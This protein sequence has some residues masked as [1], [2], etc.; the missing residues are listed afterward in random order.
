MPKNVTVILYGSEARGDARP[1]SDIDIVV[2]VDQDH[3]TQQ[4]RQE[5]IYPLFDIEFETGILINPSIYL[6]KQWGK[7]VTPFY[8][9][10]M[11]E[12]IIL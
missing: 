4:E 11:K 12:G 6:K 1:D 2:V 8:I 5:L 3:L 10:V 9:N 7:L